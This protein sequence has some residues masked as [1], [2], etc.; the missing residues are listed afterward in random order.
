VAL[1]LCHQTPEDRSRV[2]LDRSASWA[3]HTGVVALA[4]RGW[5]RAAVHSACRATAKC[6]PQISL[7]HSYLLAASSLAGLLS[8]L[9][10]SHQDGSG[11]SDRCSPLILAS[12]S[13]CL[14]REMRTYG[15]ALLYLYLS[16]IYHRAIGGAY[17]A[18]TCPRCCS[19]EKVSGRIRCAAQRLVHLGTSRHCLA[20]PH[21]SSVLLAHREFQRRAEIS[22]C[23]YGQPDLAQ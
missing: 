18:D 10:Y 6:V 2:L 23:L 14:V 3:V 22:T 4:S 13:M 12:P 21:L 17:Q 11:P 5:P 8:L 9:L 20:L 15:A 19:L 1:P 16:T 7:G